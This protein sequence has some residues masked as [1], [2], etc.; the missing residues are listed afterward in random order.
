MLN[1]PVPYNIFQYYI[2][3]KKFIQAF[4]KI[5]AKNILFFLQMHVN[6]K[7]NF[8]GEAAKKC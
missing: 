5:K 7:R 3:K 2:Q 4:E 6:I 8:V 1:P